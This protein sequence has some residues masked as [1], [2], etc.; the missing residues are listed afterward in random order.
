VAHWPELQADTFGAYDVMTSL[1]HDSGA[2]WSAPI[3]LNLDATETEH[4]FV[5]VF[6]WGGDVGMVWLDGR[7]LADWSFDDPEALLG[8]SLR[9]VRMGLDGAVSER[10]VIDELVCDCCNT[11]VAM[12]PGGPLVIYRDRTEDEIRDVVV[13]RREAGEWGAAR[14]LGNEQWR[15]EGCPVNGPAVAARGATV[16]AAWFS[17]EQ[18]IGR[19]RMA[20]STDGGAAFGAPVELD[21]DGFGQVDIVLRED[22]TAIV[23][24]WRPGANGGTELVARAQHAD[25]R[26]GET[27]HIASSP[28]AQPVD[29]PRMIAV[30][31][32]LLFAWTTLGDDGNVHAARAAGVD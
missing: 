7:Q 25:G 13:R 14:S 15:I 19:V 31:G 11:D 26:L 28:A 6:P 9:Y 1:S 16:A 18:G 21:T 20:R 23:S 24:W 8:T 32:D 29:V 12:P 5:T 17:A 3:K 30:G 4:G 22:A 27:R 2:T 10:G